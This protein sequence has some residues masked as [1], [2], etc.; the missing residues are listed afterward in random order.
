M[1]DLA[2]NRAR[3]EKEEKG[4]RPEKPRRGKKKRRRTARGGEGNWGPSTRSK[5][6]GRYS[7]KGVAQKKKIDVLWPGKK[8]KKRKKPSGKG[9]V[10]ERQANH[11]EAGSKQ[12]KILRGKSPSPGGKGEGEVQVLNSDAKEKKRSKNFLHSKTIKTGKKGDGDAFLTGGGG[13]SI[14]T[15]GERGKKGPP[16]TRGRGRKG[17][18]YGKGS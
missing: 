18:W 10:G 7:V 2:Q 6:G 5:N 8:K 15:V 16:E 17:A 4:K 3:G 11:V 1:K 9:R 13:I 12:K 14:S